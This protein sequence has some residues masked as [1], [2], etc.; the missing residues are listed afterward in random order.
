MWV[1]PNDSL[2]NFQ[3]Y[4]HLNFTLHVQ[5]VDNTD[6]ILFL[7]LSGMLNDWFAGSDMQQDIWGKVS[8][9]LGCPEL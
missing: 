9:P 5:K 7:A 6:D 8:G 3:V 1:L 2:S 4:L